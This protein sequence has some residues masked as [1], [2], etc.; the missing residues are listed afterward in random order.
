MRPKALK[1]PSPQHLLRKPRRLR[2]RRQRR[3]RCRRRGPTSNRP[4]RA[5]V[6]PA[7]AAATNE[8]SAFRIDSR[9]AGSAAA[10][11]CLDRGRARVVG[12]RRQ[13]GQAAAEKAPRGQAAH[14]RDADG[15][16]G[17]GQARGSTQAR[18]SSEAAWFGPDRKPAK[19]RGTAP[20]AARS[21]RA[22]E[23]FARTHG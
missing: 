22:L 1:R 8:T 2:R 17:G 15:S 18:G 4:N 11:T 13:T 16:T 7:I 23:T 19:T 6:T 14:H 21:P 3:S 5:A 12:K 20:G 10:A 9:I